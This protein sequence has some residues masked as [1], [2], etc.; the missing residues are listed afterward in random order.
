MG[1]TGVTTDTVTRVCAE[2]VPVESRND[3]VIVDEVFAA[4]AGAYTSKMLV[5]LVCR[6]H[7]LLIVGEV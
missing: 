5:P 1:V 3:N 7:E 6:M 2:R 4:A